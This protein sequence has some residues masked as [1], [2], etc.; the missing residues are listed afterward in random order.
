MFFKF[1][2]LRK[3]ALILVAVIISSA[4]QAKEKKAKLDSAFFLIPAKGL[5]NMKAGTLEAR[6]CLDYSFS[7]YLRRKS[8]ACVPF[9]FMRLYHI[10]SE[11]SLKANGDNN[12]VLNVT[13]QQN[14]GRHSI[15]FNNFEYY[16]WNHQ[17]PPGRVK[18][19]KINGI[20]G[21]GV[22]LEKGGWHSLAVTWQVEDKVLNVAMYM[23][24][25]L[26]SKETFNKKE[27][28]VRDISDL[29]LIGIGG[30]RNLS[31]GTILNLRISNRVKTLD[32]IKADKLFKRE[33]DT[34]FFLDGNSKF[35]KKLKMSKFINLD[36]LF[37][38][39]KNRELGVIF[40]DYKIVK[41]PDGKA[42]QFYKK[43]SR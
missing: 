39:K 21:K 20:K 14:R 32:E 34:A 15:V 30:A 42:I 23:D 12:P 17:K 36:K 5:I 27:T 35:G 6:F 33:K 28:G 38:S 11:G 29:D 31:P 13:A 24:G 19:C 41:T 25:K 9:M 4:G 22:F 18:T 16:R 2:N 40:G 37:K 1:V 10:D 7:D 3:F 26:Q 43:L 8:S